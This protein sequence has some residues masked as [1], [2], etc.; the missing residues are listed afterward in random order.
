[1]SDDV[2]EATDLA[3]EGLGLVREWEQK[4]VSRFRAIA[5]DLFR[6]G[7]RVYAM[8]Q[9]HFLEEFIHE[10]RDPAH[11]SPGYVNSAEMRAATSEA[12]RLAEALTG[13]LPTG[14]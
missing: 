2:H 10:N 11:S 6:F 8:Y 9:P 13:H 3:D 4:G 1:M 5:C 7:A 14:E 12:R